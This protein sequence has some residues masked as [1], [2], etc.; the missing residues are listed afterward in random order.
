[1]GKVP[2]F[3]TFF[4]FFLDGPKKLCIFHVIAK[5][6]SMLESKPSVAIANGST[7]AK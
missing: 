5:D 2:Y 3:D 4:D 6:R 1:M 7:L